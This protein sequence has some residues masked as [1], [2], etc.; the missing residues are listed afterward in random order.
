[1]LVNRGLFLYLCHNHWHKPARAVLWGI[2]IP[3]Y[4]SF[5]KEPPCGQ[6]PCFVDSFGLYVLAICF[7]YIGTRI[8]KL[9]SVCGHKKY[10][11]ISVSILFYRCPLGLKI[12]KLAY[13]GSY[14][15]WSLGRTRI[16]SIY[17]LCFL[18]RPSTMSNSGIHLK[19]LFGTWDYKIHSI[20]NWIIRYIVSL[21]GYRY[22]VD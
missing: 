3:S 4:H 19:V 6:S 7:M 20:S 22:I 13:Q 9:N 10:N 17:I 5:L 16:K 1:M 2:F 14:K 15:T 8:D 21:M 11:I 12:S 18:S